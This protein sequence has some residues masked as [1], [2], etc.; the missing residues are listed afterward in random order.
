MRGGMMILLFFKK[1]EES[2]TQQI[3]EENEDEMLVFLRFYVLCEIHLATKFSSCYYRQKCT[4]LRAKSERKMD[5]QAKKREE[6]LTHI[7]RERGW[8][9]KSCD[10]KEY[11]YMLWV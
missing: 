3:W 9:A 6:P 7:D 2:N 1:K 5:E 4:P 8:R 10:P 11:V